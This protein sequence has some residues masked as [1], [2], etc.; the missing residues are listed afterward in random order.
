MLSLLEKRRSIRQFKTQP[1]EKEKRDLLLEAVLRS[2]SSRNNT[3]WEFVVVTDSERLEALSC[4][5]AHGSGFLKGAPLAVVVCADPEKSDVWIEDCSIATLILHVTALSLGLGSCWVQIRQRLQ[6][7]GKTSEAYLKE[8]L[9]LPP[10]FTV[11]AIVGIGYP[12]EV[13]PGH[14]REELQFDK[15]HYNTFGQGE[16]GA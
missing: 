14:R 9:E 12:D 11:E 5:K 4:A 2:P 8:L 13:K 7:E 3:P 1:V 15:V 10:R 6:G 16:E